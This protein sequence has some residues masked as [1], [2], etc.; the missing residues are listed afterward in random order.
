MDNGV[1]L[2]F[3]RVGINIKESAKLGLI[4]ALKVDVTYLAVQKEGVFS[5]FLFDGVFRAVKVGVGIN[6]ND[7]VDE[8]Q[9]ADKQNY[10]NGKG[11]YS[12]S[13]SSQGA[14]FLVLC[15]YF[16]PM[17]IQHRIAVEARV[18][19]MLRQYLASKAVGRDVR[20]LGEGK[21]SLKAV[22]L[23]YGAGHSTHSVTCNCGDIADGNVALSRIEYKVNFFLHQMLPFL[24]TADVSAITYIFSLRLR[25]CRY[26]SRL[27]Q[28]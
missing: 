9:R 15:G 17:G 19:G 5:V 16:F 26:R 25:I 10:C 11:N 6:I 1:Y 22:A 13:L 2:V 3:S 7:I 12:L 4:K 8:Y 20:A 27:P 14:F 23:S 21:P 24:S 18:H 28:E